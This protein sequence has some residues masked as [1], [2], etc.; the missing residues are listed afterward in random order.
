M[1]SYIDLIV[2][3]RS[4]ELVERSYVYVKDF[5]KNEEY[6][7]SSQIKRSVVSIP[8]NIAEGYG[9]N[10]TIEYIR[11]LQISRGSLYEFQTQLEIVKRLE[12]ISEYGFNELSRVCLEIEKMLNSLIS[13]LKQK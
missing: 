1:K 13:K 8:S 12:F 4:I 2:W 10:Y 11:F 3:Q 7:L 9:R 5:P 6:G